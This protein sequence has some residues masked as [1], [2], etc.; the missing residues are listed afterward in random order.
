MA[1]TRNKWTFVWIAGGLACVVLILGLEVVFIGG[2]RDDAGKTAED[3]DT[4]R[5]SQST[6]GPENVDWRTRRDQLQQQAEALALEQAAK[7]IDERRIAEELG[8][9]WPVETPGR[10]LNEVKAELDTIIA[11]KVDEK[12]PPSRLDAI[13]A[14]IVAEYPM[15]TEGDTVAFTIRGGLGPDADVEG[16]FRD[17]TATH[18]QIGRRWILKSDMDRETLAKFDRDVQQKLIER[19]FRRKAYVFTQQREDYERELK[20]DIYTK[21]FRDAGYVFRQNGFVPA[22]E[23]LAAA[24]RRDIKKRAT[25]LR[26]HIEKELFENAGF[27]LRNGEW[28]PSAVSKTVGFFKKAW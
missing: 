1:T 27:V 25:S 12:F 21:G 15:K 10:S 28:E 19:D 11:A 20:R 3:L 18:V 22:N 5:S 14:E 23:V 17:V 16:V 24:V 26:P 13:R 9:P 7:E 4:P 8:L 6:S 2:F